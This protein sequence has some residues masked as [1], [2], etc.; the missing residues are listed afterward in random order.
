MNVAE[1][2]NLSEEEMEAGRQAEFAYRRGVHHA[3]CMFENIVGCKPIT[4]EMIGGLEEIASEMRYDED[5]E[6]FSYV[7]DLIAKAIEKGIL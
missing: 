2:M 5:K 7:D 1:L 4:K 3:I 6:Y